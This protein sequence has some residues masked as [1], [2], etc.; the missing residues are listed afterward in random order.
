[1]DLVLGRLTVGLIENGEGVDDFSDDSSFATVM[2]CEVPLV[3]TSKNG[4][5]TKPAQYYFCS[6]FRN[7]NLSIEFI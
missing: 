5:S 1:M 7:Q 3:I 2:E 4:K 6:A